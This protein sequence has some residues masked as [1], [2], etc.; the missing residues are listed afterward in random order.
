MFSSTDLSRQCEYRQDKTLSQ[1]NVHLCIV[2]NHI[3]SIHLHVSQ[4][5]SGLLSLLFRWLC[6][7]DSPDPEK[8]HIH[9]Q[10]TL[11]FTF[12]G[13]WV[14][15]CLW[16]LALSHVLSSSYQSLN[17]RND[18]F[19]DVWI[20]IITLNH[21]G[22]FLTAKRQRTLTKHC[23]FIMCHVFFYENHQITIATAD[24]PF[25]IY[26]LLL[27][28]RLFCK[29][30]QLSVHVVEWQKNFLKFWIIVTCHLFV[31]VF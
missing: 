29:L 8:T 3:V 15:I 22:C 2:H 7:L 25:A 27:R 5:L 30:I 6:I 12:V 19:I 28:D 10:T 9:I 21:W 13:T 1:R 16:H 17:I 14:E 20:E 11:M 4:T 23:S 24:L 18:A 31:F 26:L